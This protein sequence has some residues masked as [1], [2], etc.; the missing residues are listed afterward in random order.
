MKFLITLLAALPLVA[1]PKIADNNAHGWYMYFGDH[2][3]KQTKWGL[4]LEGQWRRE[5]VVTQWQQLLLRPA[6]NYQLNPHIMLTSGYGFV[7][8]H[9][10]GDYPAKSAFPEHRFYEQAQIASKWRKTEWTNRLRLEQ[11]NIGQTTLIPSGGYNVTSWRYENR[12]RYMLRTNVP[13][14]FGENK[15]YLGIYDEFFVNFGKNVAFNT[16]DQNRAYIALGKKLPHQTK[17]EVGFMEQTLQHRDG[18]VMEH[19]H[20]L[21][22]AIYS[23]LPFGH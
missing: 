14:P 12:F 17:L 15:Y 23:K 3:I 9:R 20:T 13:L 2:Q 10:Y 22:I 8:T 5:N 19:N 18:R 1:E 7:Q 4:H 16:F 11:R 21:Q 6:V